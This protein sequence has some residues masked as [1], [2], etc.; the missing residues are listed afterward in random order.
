MIAIVIVPF[1]SIC[2]EPGCPLPRIRFH[3]FR[4][5]AC[6][7]QAAVQALRI[8]V[9]ASEYRI[10]TQ[11]ENMKYPKI[12]YVHSRFQ[13]ASFRFA[14][15]LNYLA[16]AAISICANAVRTDAIYARI[17]FEVLWTVS[18]FGFFRCLV[19]SLLS[20]NELRSN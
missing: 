7:A 9:Y 5:I 12:K 14:F 2:F 19:I 11:P 16:T 6:I 13:I 10:Y 4:S 15:A 20:V 3:T 17:S 8:Y 1:C 18:V